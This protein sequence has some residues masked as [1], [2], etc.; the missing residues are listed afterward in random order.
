MIKPTHPHPALLIKHKNERTLVIAD[1]HIGWEIALAEEGVYVPSQ[2]SKLLQKITELINTYKPHKLLFLGD[3][4][5]TIAKAQ[6]EEWQDVPNF[7]ET[8][9]KQV[10]NIEIILGNH[11]GNLEPLLPETIKIHPKLGIKIGNIGLFHGHAW[12]PTEL[13]KSRTLIMGHIHPV[14]TF[15]DPIGYR[16]TRQVWI[17]ANCNTT[18]LEKILLKQTKSKKKPKIT[19]LIIMP[20]FNDFLGGQPINWKEKPEKTNQTSFMGPLLRSRIVD[21]ENAEVHLTDETFLGT[22]HQLRS[23][24]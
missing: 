2:T 14:I 4:K 18:Q 15:R 12:P 7:F 9:Y 8:L 1:L 23:L 20:S 3:I 16:I 21:I 24:S 6:P 10:K 13:L 5:H 22:V 11:D 19:R 17:K